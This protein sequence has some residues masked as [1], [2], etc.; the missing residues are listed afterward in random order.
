[1]K[2]STFFQRYRELALGVFMLALAVFYLYSATF[3]RVR[4][5]V[6]IDARLIPRILGS[7]VVILGILQVW[8]GIT[9]LLAARKKAREEQAAEVFINDEER[10]DVKPVLLTFI[11]I[12]GYALAFYRLGF[13]VSS[14]FCMFLQMLILTPKDKSRPGLFFGISLATA[15][16]VYIAFRR[17]LNLSLPQG[18]LGPWF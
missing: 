17:G 16:V 6:M 11:L 9:H 1:M 3:I 15:V 7:I 14:T 5:T 8:N 2:T 10:R 18:I 13:I 12:F 4:S